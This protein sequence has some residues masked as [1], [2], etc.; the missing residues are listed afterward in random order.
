MR[1]Q[2]P[3]S[4]PKLTTPPVARSLATLLTLSAHPQTLSP[5]M[6]HVSLTSLLSPSNR[7]PGTSS[8]LH[9]H[10]RADIFPRAPPPRPSPFAFALSESLADEPQEEFKTVAQEL[11][12]AQQ[13]ES[14]HSSSEAEAIDY[15]SSS[16][17]GTQL[18]PLPLSRPS[19]AIPIP[20][21]S[22]S[23]SRPGSQSSSLP[24]SATHFSPIQSRALPLG[25]SSAS[26]PTWSRRRRRR[27]KRHASVSPGPASIEERRRAR[28][29]TDA[30]DEGVEV[31]HVFLE[32]VDAAKTF[33]SMSPRISGTN[34]GGSNEGTSGGRYATGTLSPVPPPR[35]ER[36]WTPEADGVS[37]PSLSFPF[38]DP[39]LAS[40][41]P[42]VDLSSGED[43]SVEPSAKARGSV[44]P[45]GVGEPGEA[46]GWLGWLGGTVWFKVWH[47]IGLA[48]I[49]LGVGVGAGFVLPCSLPRFAR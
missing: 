43:A 11:E 31:N 3:L 27:G 20:F 25:P 12:D 28:A 14:N 38:S 39:V 45:K 49:V 1:L 37:S 33:M 15:S 48:G 2:L 23:H 21:S 30:E 19:R 16:D 29:M 7:S 41:V 8:P 22:R 44:A 26:P 17:D 47:L 6:S 34:G 42:T 18:A 9:T 35:I 24:S 10:S 5:A 13:W 46:K 36:Q 40:S 32:L 4:H